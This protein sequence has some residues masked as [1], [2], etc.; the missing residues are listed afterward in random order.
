MGSGRA[1]SNEAIGGTKGKEWRT[2]RSKKTLRS[3]RG[4][5][6]EGAGQ[7]CTVGE[8]GRM[9]RQGGCWNAIHIDIHTCGQARPAAHG[10]ESRQRTATAATQA[11]SSTASQRHSIPALPTTAR[12]SEKV[13]RGTGMSVGGDSQSQRATTFC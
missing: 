4:G 1:R 2:A 5:E 9:C 6:Q 10:V 7:R 13:N 12:H 3:A 11:H 8:I